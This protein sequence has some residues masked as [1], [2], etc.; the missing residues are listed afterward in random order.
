MDNTKVRV[1]NVTKSLWETSATSAY[2]IK[3]RKKQIGNFKGDR[4][5]RWCEKGNV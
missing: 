1:E 3:R 5:E 2:L 4:N